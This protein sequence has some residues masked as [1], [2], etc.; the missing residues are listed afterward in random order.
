MTMLTLSP[1]MKA[2]LEKVGG[3]PESRAIELL[4]SGIKENLKECELEVYNLAYPT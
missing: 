3:E 1:F 4:I 2:I